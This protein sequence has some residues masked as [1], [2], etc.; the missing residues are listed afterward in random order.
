MGNLEQEMLY[1]MAME[2]T[3]GDEFASDEFVDNVL[4]GEM[5]DTTE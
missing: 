5:N 4:D 3:N 1:E 2:A